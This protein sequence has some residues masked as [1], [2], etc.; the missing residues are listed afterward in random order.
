MHDYILNN[1]NNFLSTA[2]KNPIS[3]YSMKEFN[4]LI[5]LSDRYDTN[6]TVM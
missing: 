4:R 2:N 3:L 6:T 5:N 1:S